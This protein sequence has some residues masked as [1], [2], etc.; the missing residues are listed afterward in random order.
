MRSRI[1]PKEWATPCYDAVNRPRHA[2]V[3]LTD[4]GISILAPPGGSA[5]FTVGQLSQVREILRE[6]GEAWIADHQARRGEP[7]GDASQ[8]IG[9]D[10]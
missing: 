3:A 10:V 8:D 4:K 6:A 7:N 2:T 9:R 1:H 5:T